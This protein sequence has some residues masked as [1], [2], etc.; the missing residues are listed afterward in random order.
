MFTPC[1]QKPYQNELKFVGSDTIRTQSILR[2]KERNHL[3]S[4]LHVQAIKSDEQDSCKTICENQKL[5]CSKASFPFINNCDVMKKHFKCNSQ[6]FIGNEKYYPI[7]DGSCHLSN[8]FDFDCDLKNPN[9]G[10]RL[11]PCREKDF[12]DNF[13]A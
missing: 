3:M 6:C 13:S 4:K 10:T 1:D 11:C 12:I 2:N 9:K 8:N 5:V 7:F